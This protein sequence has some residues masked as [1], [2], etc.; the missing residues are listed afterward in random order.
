[1]RVHVVQKGDTLWKIA[2]QYSIGFDEL[3][4]LNAHLANPDYIV[5]GMEIYLPDGHHVKEKPKE[6]IKEKPIEKPHNVVPPHT[7]APQPPKVEQPIAP[8]PHW[9]PPQPVWPE[10]NLYMPWHIDM[11]QMQPMMPPPQMQQP[12]MPPPQPPMMPLPEVQKPPKVEQ[13]IVPRPEIQQPPQVQQPIMPL[14]EVQQPMFPQMMPCQPMPPMCMPPMHM[15]CCSPM[16]MP[17]DMMMYPQM[18][19]PMQP[20]PN[21]PQFVEGEQQA[22]PMMEHEM[23]TENIS[24]E[25][26]QPYPYAPCPQ[27]MPLPCQPMPCPP[28]QY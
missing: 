13:P 24:D 25:M 27:M 23:C 9:Q 3:K 10:F 19:M 7:P 28:W 17:Y 4:R 5:P 14:P 12:I 2:K 21:M 8:Q 22:S 20:Y 26:N 1:M 6:H 18:Q 16:P 15:M 11:M